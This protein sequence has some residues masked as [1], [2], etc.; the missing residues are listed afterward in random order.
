MMEHFY[1][2]KKKNCHRNSVFGGGGK[3]SKMKGK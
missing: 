1:E 3:S 2:Q